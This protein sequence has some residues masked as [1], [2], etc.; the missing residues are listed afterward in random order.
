MLLYFV[1]LGSYCLG[2]FAYLGAFELGLPAV[3]AKIVGV[4][5]GSAPPAVLIRRWWLR[6]RRERALQAAA[7]QPAPAP[8]PA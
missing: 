3:A 2:F 4:L 6:R 5:V 7:P 8:P 1:A